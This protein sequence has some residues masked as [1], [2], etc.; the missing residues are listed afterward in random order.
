MATYKLNDGL[1]NMTLYWD[2][3]YTNMKV[4]VLVLVQV[5]CP[6]TMV[7]LTFPATRTTSPLKSKSEV[8]LS[9]KIEERSRHWLNFSCFLHIP[10]A[11]HEHNI[12]RAPCVNRHHLYIVMSTL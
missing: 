9:V 4:I 12:Y 8:N 7:R 2:V 6:G 11:I 10:K 1:P 5:P 3:V